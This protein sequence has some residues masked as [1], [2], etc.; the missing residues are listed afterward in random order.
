MEIMEMNDGMLNQISK[1]KYTK[2]K[3]PDGIRLKILKKVQGK[4]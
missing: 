4:Q 2:W 3:Q 1:T